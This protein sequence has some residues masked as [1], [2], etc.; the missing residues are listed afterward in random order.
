[1][2]M[3]Y[4]HWCVFLAYLLCIYNHPINFEV[5][6]LKTIIMQACSL[7]FLY[8]DNTF[9]LISLDCIMILRDQN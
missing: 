3:V 6:I 4:S 2:N 5:F 7:L 1:M 8:L 9:K